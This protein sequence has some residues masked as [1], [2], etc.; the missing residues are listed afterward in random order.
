MTRKPAI[1]AAARMLL[2]GAIAAAAGGCAT[3]YQLTLMPRDSGKVYVGVAEDSGGGEGTMSVT[4]E[5]RTY[6]GTWVEVIPSRSMGYVSGGY[7]GRHRGFGLGGVISMDNPYGGAAK[8]LLRAADGAGLRCDL[9]GGS[10]QPGGG[11]CR[12]DK[13]LE[14]DVQIRVA[15]RQ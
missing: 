1:T 3:N 15:P 12:D 6:A 13:G 8:A 7:G 4:I 5:G 10:G 2:A 14:Y 9:R 11:V